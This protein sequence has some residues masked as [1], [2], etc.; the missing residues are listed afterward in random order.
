MLNPVPQK[1]KLA[2][3]HRITCSKCK[4]KDIVAEYQDTHARTNHIGKRVKFTVSRA[5]NQ[6]QLGFTRRVK[7]SICLNTVKSTPKML[8][9]I[10]RTTTVQI[11]WI[12]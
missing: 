10:F 6:S 8:A 3:R 9:Q 4:K 2:Y 11:W 12:H 1:R 5:L 7:Q